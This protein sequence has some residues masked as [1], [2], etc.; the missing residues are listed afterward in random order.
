M[1]ICGERIDARRNRKSRIGPLIRKR[2]GAAGG[3]GLVGGAEDT[4]KGLQRREHG[5][6]RRL[7]TNEGGVPSWS[8]R[9]C[10]GR[11]SQ[12]RKLVQTTSPCAGRELARLWAETARHER[13]TVMRWTDCGETAWPCKRR[14]RRFPVC[15]C[16]RCERCERCESVPRTHDSTQMQYLLVEPGQRNDAHVVA[17]S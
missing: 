10:L 1:L 5:R 14:G 17:M 9:W 4:K 12:Q 13:E 16:L 8:R 11:A 15:L 3:R 2:L 6:L 7:A